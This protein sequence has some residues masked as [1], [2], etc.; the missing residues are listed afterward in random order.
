MVFKDFVV[1]SKNASTS[2]QVPNV[3]SCFLA[4]GF[5]NVYFSRFCISSEAQVDTSLLVWF[6]FTCQRALV[7][8][9]LV[10]PSFDHSYALSVRTSVLLSYKLDSCHRVRLNDTV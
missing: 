9:P 10:G 6:F 4:N 5:I 8:A 7:P 3:L 1:K 2:P